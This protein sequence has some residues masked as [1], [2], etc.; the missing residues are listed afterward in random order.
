MK[1]I[2]VLGYG[3][4]GSGVVE[5]LEKNSENIGRKAGDQL[6]VKYIL[7]RRSFSGTLTRKKW[8]RILT[9]L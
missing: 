2:A 4:V 1:Q 5:V 7:V 9:P 6:K 8:C 3:V